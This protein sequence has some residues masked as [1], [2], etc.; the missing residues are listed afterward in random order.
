MSVY[1]DIL[2]V[3]ICIWRLVWLIFIIWPYLIWCLALRVILLKSKKFKWWMAYMVPWPC[4]VM[5]PSQGDNKSIYRPVTISVQ[6]IYISFSTA[7]Q[8]YKARFYN[9]LGTRHKT[10]H[11]M[12]RLSAVTMMNLLQRCLKFQMSTVNLK[13]WILST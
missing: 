1:C 5:P 3:C 9:I 13:T 6:A 10:R 12:S 4:I 11:D 8:V 7:L 2:W